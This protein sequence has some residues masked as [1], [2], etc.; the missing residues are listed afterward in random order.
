MSTKQQSKDQSL[1]LFGETSR[2]SAAAIWPTVKASFMSQKQF[3][4]LLILTLLLYNKLL[5][6][7]VKP[8]GDRK[9]LF[10]TQIPTPRTARPY[11][12]FTA[13]WRVNGFNIGHK[14]TQY[15]RPGEE[16]HGMAGSR[17]LICWWT[18][19][20]RQPR[21]LQSPTFSNAMN[22][23]GKTKQ[24]QFH[25]EILLHYQCWK[26][27]HVYR[28]RR[29]MNRSSEVCDCT[30]TCSHQVTESKNRLRVFG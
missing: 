4:H 10:N 14:W 15:I 19:G 8:N 24:I 2:P 23:L 7:G 5:K 9:M 13:D 1:Q 16:A 28:E 3:A 30:M 26:L 18:Q 20:G 6:R 12:M 25:V 27:W 17:I 11:V 22:P 21:A 29:Y